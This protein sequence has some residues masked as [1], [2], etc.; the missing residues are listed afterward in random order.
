MKKLYLIVLSIITLSFFS[1]KIWMNN[2]NIFEEIEEEV[3]KANADKATLYIRYAMNK[4][5]K[6]DPDGTTVVKVGYPYRVSAVTELEYGFKRWAAFSTKQKRENGDYFIYT[7]K[8]DKN[9]DI[10]FITDENYE[11]QIK[12]YELSSDIVEF[13]D[14]ESPSTRV[15]VKQARDD[16]FIVP[17]I[18]QR[19]TV[20]YTNLKSATKVVKNLTVQI[21]FSKPMDPESFKN[22]DNVYDKITVTQGIMQYDGGDSELISE[23][24]TDHFK[25]DENMFSSSKKTIYVRFKDEYIKEGYVSNSSVTITISKEVKDEY[26]FEMTDHNEISFSVGN[27]ADS[28]APRI[29]WLSAGSGENFEDFMGVYEYEGTINSLGGYAKMK[30]EGA[31]KTPSNNIEDSFFDNYI[32][33]RIGQDSN[34]IMRVFAEDLA[35]AGSG[36]SLEG[37]ESDVT[38]LAIRAIHMYNSDGT[39]DKDAKM[40]PISYLP[41]ASQ[42]NNTSI[43]GSYRDLVN[44]ANDKLKQTDNLKDNELVDATHGSLFEYDLSAMPDGLI[45]VDVSAIDHVDNQGFYDG[46]SNSSEYGNGYTS[47]FIVKDTTAPDAEANKNFVQADLSIVPNGRGMFNEEYYK[48]LAVIQTAD[49]II[50][51]KG[52]NRLISPNSELKWIVNPGKDTSWQNS[53]T[54]EDSRWRLVKDGYTPA[55]SSLPTE[56]GPVDFTYALMDNLGNISKAVIFN[57]V[58]YDNTVPTI[59]DIII[60]GING[61]ISQSITGNILE[62]QVISVPVS[63]DTAGLESVTITTAC[64]KDGVTSAEYDKPFASNSLVVKVDDKTVPYKIDGKKLTFDNTIV[65]ESTVTIQGLQIA[66]ADNVVDNS[67]YRISIAVTDAALNTSTIHTCNIKND[68]TAPVINYIKVNNISNGIAGSSAN[69]NSAEYWTIENTPQTALYINLTETNTGAKVFDFTGSSIKLRDDSVLIWKNEE[70]PADVIEI[71]T[72]ANKLTITDE[73][74]T[75]ITEENGGEVIIRNVDLAEENRVSLTISDLVTNTSTQATNFTLAGGSVIDVFRYDGNTPSVDNVVLKDQEPGTGGNAET[76][77]TDSEYVEATV[78]VSATASGVYQITVDGATFGATTLVNNKQAGDETEGFAVS[79]DGRTITLRT[80]GNT[81]NRLLKGT[82]DIKIG[83]VKL[84]AGDGDKVVSFTVTSLAERTSAVTDAAQAE[85]RLDKTAPAW[86][87]DGIFV[88]ASNAG[89]DGTL[90]STIYPHSSTSSSGNIKLGGSVY[91]YTNDTINISADISDTNRKDNNVDLFI[92]D[93]KTPVAEFKN[94]APGTHLV[95]AVD[96]AGNKSEVKTFYVIADISGPDAFDGYITFAMPTGGN[97]YRGNAETDSTKNYILKQNANPYKINVNLAGITSADVDVHGNVRA[98]LRRYAELDPLETA[99]PIEYYAFSTNGSQNW[100]P[101]AS[102]GQITIDLPHSS[103]ECTPYTVY[104]KDGCG[105]I[106]SATIPVNWKV[107]GNVVLGQKDLSDSLYPNAAKGITYYKGDETPV[108]TLTGFTDTCFYPNDSV[109][110]GINKS[111]DKY[112]LKSRVLAWPNNETRPERSDFYSSSIDATRFSNWSYL[113]LKT[114]EDS[115]NMAHHYPNYDVTSVYKL[116]Y[117][118]EDKLG[119]YTI[120]QLNDDSNGNNNELWMYDNTPPTITVETA[121]NVNTIDNINYYSDVST[122]SLNITDTQ[123]GIEWDGSSHYTGN[124]V[125]NSLTAITYSLESIDP[126]SNFTLKINGLKDYVENVMPDTEGLAVNSKAEWVK[127]TAPT[128]ATAAASIIDWDGTVSGTSNYTSELSTE[129]DGSKKISVKS[130]RSVTKLKFGLKVNSSDSADMLGWIIRTEPLAESDFEDFYD[131]SRIAHTDEN[132]DVTGDIIVLTRNR[133]DEYEYIYNKSD[134]S[135]KWENIENKTQYFYAVNRA[136]LVSHTPIIV[137]FAENP[138]PAISSK[139]YTDVKPYDGI[140]YI[141]ESSKIKFVANKDSADNYVAITKIEFYIGNSSTAALTKD[142]TAAPVTEYELTSA[143]VNVLPMLYNESLTVKLYT[144]TEESEKY[145]LSDGEQSISNIWNYDSI[146]PVINRI[147]VSGIKAGTTDG[148]STEYWTS[149]DSPQIELKINLTDTNTGAMVFDFSGS[150]IKLRDDT[151]VI[152]GGNELA[153]TRSV[154]NNKFVIADESTIK[155]VASGGEVTIQNFDL[156][157]NGGADTVKLVVSDFVMNTSTSV[158]SFTTKNEQNSDIIIN[159]FKYDGSTPLVNSVVLRDQGAGSGG[160]VAGLASTGYTDNEYIEAT[161]NVKATPSGVYQITVNG[162]S[163]DESTLVDNKEASDSVEGFT[164]SEDGKTITLRTNDN[165]VNRIKRGTFDIKFNNVKLPDGD[166]DKNV[167]FT[168]TSLANRTSAVTDAARASIR[169]D[170]TAPVWI[171]DGI[172]V[173]ESNSDT[174]KIYPH[175]STSSSGNIKISD[176]IYFY[177]KDNINIAASVSD[178]NRRDNNVDLYIDGETSPVAE[179]VN[180]APGTH[181]VYSVDKAG[182]KSATLTFYVI[183]DISGPDSFDGYIT[184]TMPD[185]GN[186]YRGNAATAT[187]VTVANNDSAAT[188]TASTTSVTAQNYIIKQNANPYKIVVKLAGVTTEDDDVHGDARAEL[189]RFAELDPLP[190]TDLEPLAGK[191]P[192]EYYAVSMDGTQNWQPIG[193]GT[194]TIDLP[195]T[196]TATA[197][198]YVV[199]LKDGCGNV[200]RE[201]VPV[202]WTV[203]GSVTIAEKN[204]SSSSLYV[205]TEKQ[206]TYYKGETTPVIYLTDYNDSCYYPEL[207]NSTSSSTEP[208]D[209]AYTLKSRLLVWTNP[210]SAPI[211]SDFYSTSI[212]ESRLTD[213]QYLTLKSDSAADSLAMEHHYPK[214]ESTS[215]YTLYYIIEDWLGNYTIKQLENDEGG[216]V[217]FGNEAGNNAGSYETRTSITKTSFWMYDNTTPSIIVGAASEKINTIDGINYYGVNSQLQLNITDTQSGIEYDG[218][219]YYTGNAVENTLS[220][221]YPLTQVNPDS[222]AELKIHGLKDYVENVMPDTESLEYNETGSWLKQA[223]PTLPTTSDDAVTVIN[224]E[225]SVNGTGGTSCGEG[226]YTAN[227]AE[228]TETQGTIFNVIAPRSVTSMTFALSVVQKKYAPDGTLVDDDT[229]LLGWIVRSSKLKSPEAFYNKDRVGSDINSASFTK[230]N[231]G[232]YEYTYTKTDTS[233]KWNEITNKKQYFYAVNRAGLISSKPI[234]IEFVNNPV[235]QISERILTGV[236][237]VE[238]ADVTDINFLNPGSKVKFVSDVP[239]TKIEYYKGEGN[240]LALTKTFASVATEYELVNTEVLSTLT[241]DQQTGQKLLV[242][243][244]TATEESAKYE[245]TATGYAA[246]NLWEY[247]PTV[248]EI[249]NV[250]VPGIKEGSTSGTA[251]DAEYWSTTSTDKTDIYITLKDTD[252]GVRIFDFKDS[253][254][255]LTTASKL[256]KLID[257]GAGQAATEQE[258]TDI[259]VD[260]SSSENKLTINKYNDAIKG[261]GVQIKISDVQLV[262]SNNTVNLVLKDCAS[263][264]STAAIKFDIDS[265]TPTLDTA[266]IQIDSFNYDS[267]APLVSNFVLSDKE[268]EIVDGFEIPVD[269]E[270]TDDRFVKASFNVSESESGVYK[271]TVISAEFVQGTTTISIDNTPVV[272]T[273][274]ST[275]DS[276][277]LVVSSA[278]FDNHK[279]FRDSSALSVVIEN[280][281]LTEGD[282][283]KTVLI[284]AT[285]IG[286]KDSSPVSDS[287]T[288]DTTRPEWNDERGLYT[289]QTLSTIYPRSADGTEKAYGLANVGSGESEN[290]VFFYTHGDQLKLY[291]DVTEANK[292]ETNGTQKCVYFKVVSG[293]ISEID[294]TTSTNYYQDNY[295]YLGLTPLGDTCRFIAYAVD[296]AGNA[297]TLKSYT[298]VKDTT[299]PSSIKDYITFTEAMDGGVSVGQVFRG[300]DTQYAIQKL[301]ADIEPYKIIIKLGSA[302][303]VA[304][305]DKGID[306]SLITSGPT[307]AYSELWKNDTGSINAQFKTVQ[308]SPIEYFAVTEETDVDTVVAPTSSSSWIRIED[309]EAHRAGLNPLGET[310]GKLTVNGGGS[311]TISLPKTGTCDTIYLH[312]KDGCGNI[313]TTKLSVV[314]DDDNELIWIIDDK[315]GLGGNDVGNYYVEFKGNETAAV[316]DNSTDIENSQAHISINSPYDSSD[317]DSG[318]IAINEGVTYYKKAGSNPS[319]PKLILRYKDECKITSGTAS[320][321]NY[322]LRGRL[323]AGNFGENGPSQEEFLSDDSSVYTR[324]WATNWEYAIVPDTDTSCELEFTFPDDSDS[325]ITGS[326]ATNTYELWYMVADAVGNRKIMQVKNRESSTSTTDVTEWMYDDQAPTLDIENDVTFDRVNKDGSI[327]YYGETSK[328]TYTIK[329]NWA[330]IIT[331]SELIASDDTERSART[332]NKVIKDMS[333]SVRPYVTVYDI[334]GNGT[335]LYL[336]EPSSSWTRQNAPSLSNITNAS[337]TSDTEPASAS[338]SATGRFYAIVSGDSSSG[339]EYTVM[340]ARS[341]QNITAAL[342][343]SQSK[344][345]SGS[346]TSDS[347]PLLGWVISDSALDSTALNAFYSNSTLRATNCSTE[348]SEVSPEDSGIY[349]N[350]TYTFA[351][352]DPTTTWKS[353]FTGTKY[354]YAVNKAGII[355]QAPIKITFAEN[356]IPVISGDITYN[357]IETES[358]NYIK[359]GNYLNAT[360][361]TVANPSSISFTSNIGLTNCKLASG[362]ISENKSYSSSTTSHTLTFPQEIWS[363]LS[364]GELKLV[365]STATEDSDEITLSKG[366][367]SS[368]TYDATR[369]EFNWNLKHNDGTT[370][371][372]LNQGTLFVTT[373]VAKL[374]FNDVSETVKRYEY[375]ESSAT[376]WQPLADPYPLSVPANETTYTTYNFRAIDLAGNPSEVKT[377]KVQKDTSGP[378]GS[379]SNITTS[380]TGTDNTKINET[381]VSNNSKTIYYNPDFVSGVSITVNVTDSGVGMPTQY[382]YYKLSTDAAPV[383]EDVTEQETTGNSISL[384]FAANTVYHCQVIAKD[385]LGNA[386]VLHTYTFNGITPSA[387]VTPSY[388]LDSTSVDNSTIQRYAQSNTGTNYTVYYNHERVNQLVIAISENAGNG[389]HYYYHT[390][391][392]SSDVE[393][394]GATQTFSL[395]VSGNTLTETYTIIAKDI[396]DYEKTLATFTVNGNVPNGTIGYTPVSGRTSFDD[397]NNIIYFNS[398]S[399]NGVATITLTKGSDVLAASGEAVELYYNTIDDSHKI[400]TTLQIPCPTSATESYDIIAVDSLGNQ[401]TLRTF[402]LNGTKPTG[403]IDYATAGNSTDYAQL[404]DSTVYFN[405]SQITNGIKLKKSN[406]QGARSGDTIKLYYQKNSENRIE[407]SEANTN[408]SG[409][410][411]TI[412]NPTSNDDWTATYKIIAVDSIGNET[413]LAQYTLNSNTPSGTLSFTETAND[414]SLDSNTNTIYFNQDNTS[415][416][417]LTKSNVTGAY[418]NNSIRL[419]CQ[420]GDDANSRVE[421]NSTNNNID[422]NTLKLVRPSSSDN[423]T[424]TYKI[425]A[426]DFVQNETVLG[427][428]G[429]NGNKPTGALSFTAEA[430]KTAFDDN[431]IYFNHSNITSVTFGINTLMNAANSNTIGDNLYVYYMNGTDKVI[432]TGADGTGKGLTLACPGATASYTGT[433]T[434]YAADKVGNQ[435]ELATYTLKGSAPSGSISIGEN[436]VG[437]TSGESATFTA[438]AAATDTTAGGYILTSDDTTNTT[439]IKYNPSL[440]N[441]VK[442]NPSVTDSGVGSKVRVMNGETQVSSTNYSSNVTIPITLASTWT[443]DFT[444]YD[445][446]AVDNV[447][448]STKLWTYMFRAYTTAPTTVT[449]NDG[450]NYGNIDNNNQNNDKIV[451]NYNGT[452]SEVKGIKGHSIKSGSEN[453]EHIKD[454]GGDHIIING[455]VTFNIKINNSSNLISD[456]VSYKVS[457]THNNAGEDYINWKEDVNTTKDWQPLQTITNGTIVVTIG[458]NDVQYFQTFV[459]IWIKD[460]IGNM[461]VYNLVYPNDSK[462]WGWFSPDTYTPI[463][464]IDCTPQKNGSNTGDSDCIVSNNKASFTYENGVGTTETTLIYNDVNKIDAIKFVIT[465]TGTDKD[466]LPYQRIPLASSPLSF[467]NGETTLS[468]T[469]NTVSLSGVDR[470][471]G[472]DVFATDK[473]GKTTKVLHVA[474]AVDSTGPT[475]ELNSFVL[476]KWGAS[477]TT[478]EKYYKTETQ[479][480]GKK[481]IYTYNSNEVENIKLKVTASD[482]NGIKTEE[483]NSQQKERVYIGTKAINNGEETTVNLSDLNISGNTSVDITAT[484]KLGNQSTLYTIEFRPLQNYLDGNVTFAFKKV[485]GSGESA[486]VSDADSQYY[487]VT[488]GLNN[489]KL[490]IATDAAITYNPS[491]VTNVVFTPSISGET[492]TSM[493]YKKDNAETETSM[494]DFSLTLASGTFEIYAKYKDTQNGYTEYPLKLFTLTLIAEDSFVQTNPNIWSF[495]KPFAGLT[496]SSSTNVSQYDSAFNNSSFGSNAFEQLNDFVDYPR[497]ARKAK[498]ASKT[499]KNAKKV[500]EIATTEVVTAQNQYKETANTAVEEALPSNITSLADVVSSI[501]KV[502]EVASVSAVT[503]A[504]SA[505]ATN[506]ATP[507][508]VIST[509]EQLVSEEAVIPAEVSET[510]AAVETAVPDQVLAPVESVIQSEQ[511]LAEN[512]LVAENTTIIQNHSNYYEDEVVDLKLIYVVIAILLAAVAVVAVIVITWKQKVRK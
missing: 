483:V 167:Y 395:P 350:N 362:S 473:L 397:S 337:F 122:L 248:P 247:D 107:D 300:S 414:T 360:S 96:K 344:V 409:D 342:S 301:G 327:Y 152:W 44:K 433:Y 468:A 136:G 372:I 348:Y 458:K 22:E 294:I 32:T 239:V 226:N 26:G 212:E 222:S 64:I 4:Q 48:K 118:V 373:D 435:I 382:L 444:T 434:L 463:G 475:G 495:I 355:C 466:N 192:V 219:D 277:G 443:S 308:K 425:I 137:E 457:Y 217:G 80:S 354:F 328:T 125:V 180:V 130:P 225:G 29:T 440:V 196:D 120:T 285:N 371:A 166:G 138:V 424:V 439:T 1:C 133:Y 411:L 250:F 330:G 104:L 23:D 126:R 326:S 509:L 343:V 275:T 505:Q 469:D 108:I 349:Q 504:S 173:A 154:E 467:K 486:T 292:P 141:K 476:T 41:Y 151:K 51:D 280:L 230:N 490:E 45:R 117:I 484:D 209:H 105:N 363:G 416:L 246:S 174:T 488:P 286:N 422:G 60:T 76:G 116:F 189:G 313:T 67:T 347:T 190:G 282:E 181:T 214:Y 199:Y 256:Y 56:D 193:N 405:R 220:P 165:T 128:P 295:E 185:G 291:A 445:V 113:T 448:N 132:G 184:F 428:Y 263:Q 203:D 361:V 317:S 98:E 455:D 90:K 359:S 176:V 283:E 168:V 338:T 438:V 446:Y 218:T 97:I 72:A 18:A 79:A 146:A 341:K 144:A 161:L 470:Y 170:K 119:N 46:G 259:T 102:N 139:T 498:K 329:D 182:N 302:E 315:I 43:T 140:N 464:N 400:T 17:I 241:T 143:E 406:I 453:M 407:F 94:V 296:K 147:F 507:A 333:V 413:Q 482:E 221:Y 364:S 479:N 42:Q 390:N 381:S 134:T 379:Y 420:T 62:N 61:Y 233:K 142:F 245:L 391:S 378:N 39:E 436:D 366:S 290:D 5:G 205:N 454:T 186:I 131:K 171:G 235:P 380:F 402:T 352:A 293:L 59:G 36:Q 465:D 500:A 305:E 13:E 376:E 367:V 304:S 163:F 437:S 53:I 78:S 478:N 100:T 399:E 73:Y 511:E 270:F 129:V 11:A 356:T 86:I 325:T 216:K 40:T 68:S 426:V 262:A 103:G 240:T 82:F 50:K 508:K 224:C 410:I 351:K 223:T 418:A 324:S 370:A 83:N 89:A 215:A 450:I 279:I 249:T 412:P 297:S 451:W 229:D 169:L 9:K 148:N 316:Y 114:P 441:T 384:S 124:N 33:N 288:L 340:A 394:T 307:V 335:T 254:I 200:S 474:F 211:K 207:A 178:V 403:A 155:T 145:E 35:G 15:T 401:K 461:N 387:S 417:E 274:A 19:P 306:G 123:S 396:V 232:K 195:V 121:G 269:P 273:A 496:D 423:W 236:T 160:E 477:T 480:N 497:K 257:N 358:V 460:A 159:N 375:K 228:D 462:T 276:S 284:T 231:D 392:N 52:H 2:D 510:I 177:T 37:M 404:V 253:S 485:S 265:T 398:M 188:S 127:Q 334:L 323:I 25:F 357:D 267:S 175:A 503:S 339:K 314:P 419:Y 66:D 135:Q 311:I 289:T 493:Y 442:L 456:K 8:Q 213:W 415:E 208:A 21:Q 69:G 238:G 34:L 421:F 261:N 179:Y 512:S 487:Q 408:L 383:W 491:E 77:F 281:R 255:N 12:P 237:K 310:V 266:I 70:L 264:A 447:G 336:S 3:K 210:S 389:V 430:N 312:L 16:I 459:F 84:P 320:T 10:Y 299:A 14:I 95:Y 38:R 345:E 87:G 91:F 242:K 47:L 368:W 88:A 71:D 49:G 227:A 252:T 303:G 65:G 287:I 74:K 202:N 7:D 191:S 365:L 55:E 429:L 112:T 449:R 309:T 271:L 369:P 393:I 206:I 109:E 157:E 149:A 24:I 111:T 30:L 472:I 331:N 489:G 374:V 353:N 201:I 158:E 92:D 346:N 153:I 244:Y 234:I 492:I 106:K 502:D 164:I 85:I 298:L 75:I 6:T 197:T 58:T 99:S 20:F 172:F 471:S 260:A 57:S 28:L 499:R 268:K 54:A 204:L 452:S 319:V 63:D 156:L 278:T 501:D 481:F 494:T 187:T 322:S 272:Y 321:S 110:A 243:L 427:T 388:K 198:P 385:A 431:I 506:T 386:S 27:M 194:I 258:I 93:E 251:D 31:N 162:A 115:F 101:I 377:V 432:L 318:S 150:T 81:V 332:T 183:G